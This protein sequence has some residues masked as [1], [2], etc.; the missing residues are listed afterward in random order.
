[1]ESATGRGFRGEPETL[2]A[3]VA[4]GRGFNLGREIEETIIGK[5]RELFIRV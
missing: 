5:R 3:K 2:L 4:V 1:M